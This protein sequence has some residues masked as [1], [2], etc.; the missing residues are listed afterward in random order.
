MN[1]ILLV[2]LCFSSFLS[3]AQSGY[4][5]GF[6]VK[7][8]KDT[9]VLLAYYNGEQTLRRDTARVD[10]K[11]TFFFE[12]SKPLLQGLYL[13]YQDNLIR[14]YP[15]TLTARMLLA[16]W[17][18]EIPEAPLQSDGTP[19]PAFRLN[20]YS[21]HYFDHF[22]LRDDAMLCVRE[23]LDELYHVD[24][25]PTIYI[26]DNRKKIIRQ[27]AEHRS[28]GGFFNYLVSPSSEELTYWPSNGA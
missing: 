19:D 24:L 17:E 15:K 9:T 12:G 22:D 27:K 28:V 18:I 26:I 16:N 6:H 8:W 1:R 2:L 14:K 20:Y 10:K 3:Q 21:V 11:A 4:G 23:P 7:G 25:T 5:L 13:T